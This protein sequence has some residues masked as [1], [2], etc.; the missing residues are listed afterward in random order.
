MKTA[1]DWFEE[2]LSGEP[3]T[4]E[5][6]IEVIKM[7]QE[8]VIEEACKTCIENTVLVENMRTSG[9]P[10]VDESKFNSNYDFYIDKESI[11][12]C[13]NILKQKL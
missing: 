13:A 8:E 7:I 1:K 11:I 3:L 4:Q 2:E 9:T 10:I 6:V 12:N 5:S